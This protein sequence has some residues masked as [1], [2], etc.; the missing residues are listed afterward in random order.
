LKNAM[1]KAATNWPENSSTV[2][3]SAESI[4]SWLP[5]VGVRGKYGIL[6]ADI[7]KAV[8]EKIIGEKAFLEGP[9]AKGMNFVS[10]TKFGKYNPAFLT[11]LHAALA[12]IL[13][14][15]KFVG[16]LQELYDQK[17][18][19]YLRLY[20]L[21][22]HLA[23]NNQMVMDRYLVEV[24]DEAKMEFDSPS[25]YLQEM[26]R[27]FAEAKEREGYDVYEAF[28]CPGFWVRR[29]IDGTADEFWKLLNLTM[30]TF[31]PSFVE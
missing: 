28:T 11:K 12:V 22:Y 17:F 9:H 1:D 23:A 18:R 26:F 7:G 29:S 5:D 6:K 8:L 19:E 10:E 21:S 3:L 31:D 20:Y 15:K 30:K 24:A 4:N 16:T 25:L 13:K 14:N 2:D 27:D